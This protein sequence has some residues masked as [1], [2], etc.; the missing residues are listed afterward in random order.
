MSAPPLPGVLGDLAPILNHWGYL[1]V[2]GLILVE[3]FGVPAPGETILIAAALYAGAG[4][5]NIVAVIAIGIIAAIIG[6]N[7]GYLIGRTGGQAL[8][9]RYG[10][11]IFLTPERFAKAEQFFTRHGGK[12]VTI[13][14]FVEGLRQANGIIAGTTAMP[15]R[16]FLAFNALGAALWVGLWAGLGY[17]AGNHISTIYTQVNRY[18]LYVLVALAVLVVALVLRTVL[19]RRRAEHP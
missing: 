2:G 18:S 15:W 17:A 6:D 13:A 10:K 1:A 16:R 12:V 5:L 7:I 9:L 8:V 14:R 4:Q 3:D 11:Y 19:R